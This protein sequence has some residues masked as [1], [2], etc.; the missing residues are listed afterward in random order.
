[1][2]F[3]FARMG[4]DGSKTSLVTSTDTRVCSVHWSVSQEEEDLFE[5]IW[6]D[7]HHNKKL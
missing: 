6:L 2:I 7:C 3:A 5:F 4:N 1:M